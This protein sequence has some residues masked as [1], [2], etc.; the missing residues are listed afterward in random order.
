M[1]TYYLAAV[2]AVFIAS[3]AQILLKSSSSKSY[4]SLTKEYLNWKVVAGYTLLFGSMLINIYA[5]SKGLE[6][7]ELASLESLSYLLVPLLSCLF[8]GERVPRRRLVAIFVIM[9]GIV[10]FFS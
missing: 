5:L 9:A 7:K 6:V 3:L 4:S 1:A 10:V 8:F 2:V